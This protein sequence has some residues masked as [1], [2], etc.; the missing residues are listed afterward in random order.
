MGLG[1]MEVKAK[2]EIGYDEM[3]ACAA[4]EVKYRRR[5]YM[6]LVDSGKMNPERAAREIEVMEA[7]AGYFERLSQPELL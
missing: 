6:R 2:T 5:V 3:A 7:I 1:G 4:R